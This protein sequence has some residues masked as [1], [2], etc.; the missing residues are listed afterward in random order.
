MVVFCIN[1]PVEF[2]LLYTTRSSLDLTFKL[3]FKQYVQVDSAVFAPSGAHSIL[4]DASGTRVTTGP[5]VP[6]LESPSD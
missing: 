3:T 4:T 2:S 1:V 6:G 5:R